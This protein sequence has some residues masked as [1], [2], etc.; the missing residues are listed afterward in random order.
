MDKVSISLDDFKKI[1][2]R[3]GTI[4][5]VD[6]IPD[7]DKLLRLMVDVGEES[8]RQIVSGIREYVGDPATLIGKQ[9]PFIVNLEPRVLRGYTSAGMLLAVSDDTGLALLEPQRAVTAGSVAR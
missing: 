8:P 9:F 3:I 4:V 1:D 2:I 5:S 7:A 6:I